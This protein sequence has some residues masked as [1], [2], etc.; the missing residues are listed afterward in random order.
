M[1]KELYNKCILKPYLNTLLTCL[2]H[3]YFDQPTLTIEDLNIK[4]KM[5]REISELS[6]R[7]KQL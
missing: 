6:R 7:I 1:F 4:V 5:F 2:V 3:E